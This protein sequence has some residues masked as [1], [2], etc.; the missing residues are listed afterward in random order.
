MYLSLYAH[1][2]GNPRKSCWADATPPPAEYGI[3]V[4]ADEE[5]WKDGSGH[6]WGVRDDGLPLG[7]DGERLSK[8]PRNNLPQVPWHGFPITPLSGEKGH[9]PP[10]AFVEGWIAAGVV[11]RT[12]GRKIQRRKV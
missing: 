2:G 1:R 10:D 4:R 5:G 12:L 7:R 11:S 8:F 6:Y 9:A 3:F